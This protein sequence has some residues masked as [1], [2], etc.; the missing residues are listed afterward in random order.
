MTRLT[1]RT[2][3]I[4]GSATIVTIEV[5]GIGTSEMSPPPKRRLEAVARRHTCITA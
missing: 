3:A 4:W 2:A 5:D 1:R